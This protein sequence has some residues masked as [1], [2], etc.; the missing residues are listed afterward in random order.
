DPFHFFVHDAESSMLAPEWFNNRANAVNL[1]SPNR[2][3]FIYS[4]PEWIHEDLMANAEY[5]T[6]FWGEAH[7]L[8]FDDGALTATKSQPIWDALAAQI[9]QAVIGESI[10]WGNDFA[11]ARQSVWA[12][13]IAQV[14]TNFFPTRTATVITQ[15]RQRNQYPATAAPTFNRYGGIVPAGFDVYLTNS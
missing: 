4:N 11:K 14:R 7:R 1:T 8:L 10:R 13:K 12:A 6:V 2:N 5:R 3:N 9:D 15:L